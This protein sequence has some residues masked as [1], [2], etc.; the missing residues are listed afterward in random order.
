MEKNV[1]DKTTK[2]TKDE[3]LKQL[4]LSAY[5][6]Q[7]LIPTM[8]YNTALNYIKEKRQEMKEKKLYVPEGQT[9]LALTKL[10]KKDCG[11]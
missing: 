7:V 2:K 5:D 10:I 8:S 11:F 9:K 1:P 3:I 6:L 4:Y